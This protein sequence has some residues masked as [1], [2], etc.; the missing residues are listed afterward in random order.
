[1]ILVKKKSVKILKIKLNVK[2]DILDF[3]EFLRFQTKW[4]LHLFKLGA[5]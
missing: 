5:Y 2:V 3:K 4:L 1:M